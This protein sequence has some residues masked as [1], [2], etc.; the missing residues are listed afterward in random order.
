MLDYKERGRIPETV[1]ESKSGSESNQIINPKRDR[2]DWKGQPRVER[3]SF[4]VL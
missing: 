4:V 2:R 1:Q 3:T